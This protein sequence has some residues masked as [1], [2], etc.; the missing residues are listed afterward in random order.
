LLFTCS[1]IQLP[2]VGS[3]I[4]PLLLGDV[5]LDNGDIDV[6]DVDVDVDEKEVEVEEEEEEEASPATIIVNLFK[7]D[8]EF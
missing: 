2:D 1:I 6:V 3:I 5:V 4:I 8:N 7:L